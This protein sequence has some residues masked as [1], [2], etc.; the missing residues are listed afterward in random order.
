M[1]VS[2]FG[3]SSQDANLLNILCG[4]IFAYFYVIP[5]IFQSLFAYYVNKYGYR[6]ELMILAYVIFL[7]SLII[8]NVY[9]ANINPY[10][11]I[12]PFILQGFAYSLYAPIAY[13]C[14][15]YEVDE[16]HIGTAFG[17][18]F[19]LYNIFTAF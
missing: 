5:L 3:S 1:I 8:I 13:A 7:I 17:L 9:P 19:S 2:M 11:L 6:N 10:Y 12:I 15:K 18:L 16:K 14:I 4:Q